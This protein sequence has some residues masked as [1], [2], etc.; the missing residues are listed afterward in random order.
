MFITKLLLLYPIYT[1]SLIANDYNGAL[2][3]TVSTSI[4]SSGKGTTSR[5]IVLTN[6]LVGP[7]TIQA[8]LSP[9][10]VS[11]ARLAKMQA[12]WRAE[13]A[14]HGHN[15]PVSPSGPGSTKAVCDD[16]MHISDDDG[17]YLGND[18]S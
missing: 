18:E 14:K 10:I 5:S 9:L 1:A 8:P 6:T 16:C 15:S 11:L 12:R 17:G 13:R 7:A 3:S 4:S 2:R